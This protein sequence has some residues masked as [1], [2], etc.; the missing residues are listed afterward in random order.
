MEQLG[1][2]LMIIPVPEKRDERTELLKVS[3]QKSVPAL[4]DEDQV[5]TDSREI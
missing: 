2:S 3:E 1:L 4:F 5:I